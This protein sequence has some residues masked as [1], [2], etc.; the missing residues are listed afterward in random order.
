MEELFSLVREHNI[1]DFSYCYGSEQKHVNAS[2]EFK[3]LYSSTINLVYKCARGK[4]FRTNYI[5]FDKVFLKDYTIY[6]PNESRKSNV[7]SL[8]DDEETIRVTSISEL[9]SRDKILLINK[10]GCHYGNE[11]SSVIDNMALLFDCKLVHFYK[12]IYELVKPTY[13]KSAIKN[14]YACE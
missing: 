14:I 12:N 3:T 10:E 11:T 1:V 6:S 4:Y 8:S 13:T 9:T 2:S 7:I 5:I